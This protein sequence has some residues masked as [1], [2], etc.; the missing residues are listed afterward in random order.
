MRRRHKVPLPKQAIKLFIKLQESDLSS[1]WVFPQLNG[2]SKPISEN[3]MNL[4][5]VRAGVPSSEH[6]P[7]GFRA[8]A[9]TFL[10]QQGFDERVVETSLDHIDSNQVRRTYNRYKYWDERVE[11]AQSY[12]DYLDK[13]RR[14]VPRDNSDL[15]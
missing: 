7:H 2:K 1:K 6:C 10:N 8:S 13:L 4:A 11:M 15:I 9:S 12:A 3:G 5:L 14:P